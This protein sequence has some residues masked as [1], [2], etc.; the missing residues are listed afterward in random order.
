MSAS[1]PAQC[2]VYTTAGVVCVCVV[3]VHFQH[4]VCLLC[5]YHCWH[6]ACLCCA[7]MIVSAVCN[8]VVS[9]PLPA[10]CACVL[11]LYH[12]QL[13]VYLCCACTT[14]SAMCICIMSVCLYYCQR[15]VPVEATISP[16]TYEFLLFLYYLP[17]PTI[18]EYEYVGFQS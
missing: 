10:Q 3:S 17:I 9:V 5:L 8:C 1:L 15:N 11:C 6:S 18:W 2:C 4:S 14:A 7:Y 13:S 16:L 12:Y